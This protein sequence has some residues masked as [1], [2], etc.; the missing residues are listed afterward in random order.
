MS[1]TYRSIPS[2]L[3]LRAPFNGN[4]MSALIQGDEYVVKSYGTV[5]ARASAMMGGSILE[6]NEDRYSQTTSRHQNLVQ[7]HL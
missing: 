7:A 4:S 3:K 2:L 6:I 1:A 5:I